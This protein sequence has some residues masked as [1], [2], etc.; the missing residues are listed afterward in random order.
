[1]KKILKFLLKY[2]WIEGKLNESLQK[3]FPIEE[4]HQKFCKN[5]F[6]W[7]PYPP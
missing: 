2:F 7:P 5:I 1:M 6:L 4:T 3:Y